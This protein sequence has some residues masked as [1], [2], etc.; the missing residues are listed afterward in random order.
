MCVL[1]EMR[2]D[3]AFG[4]GKFLKLYLYKFVLRTYFIWLCSYFFSLSSFKS[5]YFDFSRGVLV[6]IISDPG[7][8]L[9]CVPSLSALPLPLASW[10]FTSSSMS[11]SPPCFCFIIF[12]QRG[13]AS[14]GFISSLKNAIPS[15]CPAWCVWWRC[16]CLFATCTECLGFPRLRAC[17]AC[18]VRLGVGLWGGSVPPSQ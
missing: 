13:I 3:P 1:S 11:P 5:L 15:F 16:G 14:L 8:Y 9:F 10:E 12:L 7:C 4:L 6:V 18:L 2:S 17:T